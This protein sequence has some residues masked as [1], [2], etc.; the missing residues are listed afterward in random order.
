M[1]KL[2]YIKELFLK[3]TKTYINIRKQVLRQNLLY[4]KGIMIKESVYQE[5]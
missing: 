3:T 4:K 2:L 1:L 5:D